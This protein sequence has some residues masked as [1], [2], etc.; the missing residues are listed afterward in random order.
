MVKPNAILLVG[1]RENI[2]TAKNLVTELDQP[3]APDTQIKVFQLLHMPALEC[4][5]VPAEFLRGGRRYGAADPADT[6]RH[7]AWRRDVVVIAD[8]RSNSLI[9]QASPRDLEEVAEL[10]KKLDVEKTPASVEV[11]I[12]PLQN[13]LASDV[14]DR[15]AERPGRAGTTAGTGQQFQQ[16]PTATNQQGQVSR[17]VQIVGIDQA[18]NKIIE[19]G[20]LTDVTIT[21]DDNS[22]ALVVK[23]PVAAAWG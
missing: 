8:Y 9:V 1:R 15:A 5:T 22:N 21:A 12:F 6:S 11:R 4:G 14:A 16:Q 17:S 18:G 7:V 13:S 10:L 23:A 20:L 2:D 3:V 19:S